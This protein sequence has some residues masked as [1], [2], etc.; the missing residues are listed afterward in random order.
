MVKDHLGNEYATN[1]KMCESWNIN[2]RVFSRRKR[3]GWTIEKALTTPQTRKTEDWTKEEIALLQAN[4]Q[5]FGTNIPGLNRSKAAIM[6]QALRF[7]IV[8]KRGWTKEQTEILKRDYP[9]YGTNIPELKEIMPSRNIAAQASRLNLRSPRRWSDEEVKI[10]QERYVECGANIPELNKTRSSIICK[11]RKLGLKTTKGLWTEEEKQILRDKYPKHGCN[12]PELSH[13]ANKT[14]MAQAKAL[15][16]KREY[17]YKDIL[18]KWQNNQ[19][20]LKCKFN[21]YK[22]GNKAEFEFEDG[23]IVLMSLHHSDTYRVTHP[24]LTSRSLKKPLFYGFKTKLI[25]TDKSNDDW[26]SMYECEC[27]LCG[28]KEIMTPQQMMEH[29][30]ICRN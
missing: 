3:L 27:T 13:K 29:S 6:R 11:A 8:N 30:K 19:S 16:I 7:G 26:I 18:N 23:T 17:P 2:E 25:L 5:K 14:I 15:G 22:R 21:G 4:Y 9:I 10:L 20:G 1:R 12:I 24:A 28:A